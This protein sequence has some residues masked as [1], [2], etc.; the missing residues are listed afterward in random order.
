MNENGNFMNK[1]DSLFTLRGA[2]IMLIITALI[3]VTLYF[4]NQLPLLMDSGFVKQYRD[5]EELKRA[6]GAGT[7]TIPSYFPEGIKWPPAF[8]IAQ[9]R[10]FVAIAME[11]QSTEVGTRAL[12]IIQTDLKGK[13]T[14]FKRLQLSNVKEEAEHLMKD[15]RLILKVG[16]CQGGIACNSLS[17]QDQRFRYEIVS[18]TSPIDTIKIAESMIR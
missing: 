17:W 13:P 2:A 12:N 1:R 18:T 5:I 16:I 3:A 7:I 11:F 4:A 14:T 6:F 10:P 15:K 9:R 8:I